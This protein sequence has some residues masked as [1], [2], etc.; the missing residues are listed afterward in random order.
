MRKEDYL[1][2]F[3]DEKRISFKLVQAAES[4]ESKNYF[5]NNYESRMSAILSVAT[6]DPD[7][8]LEDYKV[9]HKKKWTAYVFWMGRAWEKM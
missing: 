3:K 9:L 5:I 4:L 8:S 1:A 6:K 2:C 7:L